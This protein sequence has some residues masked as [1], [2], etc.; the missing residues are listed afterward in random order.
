MSEREEPSIDPQPGKL[1]EGRVEV[2]GATELAGGRATGDE[3]G[4]GERGG[5][6][7]GGYT[8]GTPE[9]VEEGAGEDREDPPGP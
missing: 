3:A 4:G 2:P 9:R 7:P 1:G 8:G 6:G 5:T